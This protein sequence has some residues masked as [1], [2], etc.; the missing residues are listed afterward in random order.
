MVVL[1]APSPAMGLS[2]TGRH[3]RI[4]D[5][6]LGERF[7][8]DDQFIYEKLVPVVQTITGFKVGES[9]RWNTRD[10]DQT[11]KK[12]PPAGDQ[13]ESSSF[14]DLLKKLLK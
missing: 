5:I 2:L 11:D 1:V 10:E 12:T 13:V 4:L 8:P 9:V 14:V 3:V 6:L 7:Q